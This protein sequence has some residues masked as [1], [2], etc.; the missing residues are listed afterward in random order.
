M[1]D[2][3]KT[4]KYSPFSQI[5]SNNISVDVKVSKF[6]NSIEMWSTLLKKG[7]RGSVSHLDVNKT[8]L[9]LWSVVIDIHHNHQEGSRRV[10]VPISDLEWIGLS[11]TGKLYT[12]TDKKKSQGRNLRKFLETL[13][14]TSTLISSTVSKSKLVARC[15]TPVKLK[16]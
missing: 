9:E 1:S 10:E 6:N 12:V 8:L 13:T 15:T 5:F 3:I 16:R 7:W 11:A 4:Q 2:K 14:F